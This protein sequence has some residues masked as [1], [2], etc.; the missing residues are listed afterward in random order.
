MILPSDVPMIEFL[1]RVELADSK[2][3]DR[4]FYNKYKTTSRRLKKLCEDK[5][6]YRCRDVDTKG[7]VYGA[8]PFIKSPSLCKQIRHKNKRNEFY[9]KLIEDPDVEILSVYTEQ[10]LLNLRADIVFELLYKGKPYNLIVEVETGCKK[11]DITKYNYLF[12]S[13][14]W[15][16][17]F[18]TKPIV[19]WV[20]N[21]TPA[22]KAIYY[23]YR[24][25][26]WDLEC[27]KEIFK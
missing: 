22:D 26:K 6:L 13:N 5:V 15:Q 27:Y 18:N 25:V 24:W 8:K 9:L 20:M 12:Y 23:P 17:Y 14:K 19:V 1:E 7:Y 3:L 11:A 21:E 16:E 4:L 2:L 10:P